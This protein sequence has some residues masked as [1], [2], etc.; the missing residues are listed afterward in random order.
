MEDLLRREP[1]AVDTAEIAGYL[2]GERVLVTGAGGSIG[3]ELVR[4][5]IAVGP[6]EILLLGHGE[7]SIFELEQELRRDYNLN[8]TCL[9]VDTRDEERLRAVFQKYRPTVV[10]H[11]AAHKHVPLMEMNPEEAITVNVLGTR[12][13]ARIASEFGVRRFVMISTDKAVNPT[14]VMGASKRVAELVVQAESR[15]SPTDFATVRFG[16]VLGSRGIVVPLMRKQIERGGPVTVTHADIVRYFMT[17]PEA[18]SLVI[19]R[20]AMGGPGIIYLLDM[21][22]P[23]QYHRPRPRSYPAFRPRSRQG[24][25]HRD[26]GPAPRRE[27]L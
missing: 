3:S 5:I 22:D 27:V 20:G 1:F 26:H 12:N 23:V 4:Q 18:V 21:G 19:R 9:I 15:R 14:S 16:N 2:S 7:F 24:H 25:S 11:A 17:I 6:A 8:P 13:V 10:F